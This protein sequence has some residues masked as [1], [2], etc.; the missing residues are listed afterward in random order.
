MLCF[1][2][3]SGVENHSLRLGLMRFCMF[4][5]LSYASATTI[6]KVSPGSL[7]SL[8]PESQNKYM[9]TDLPQSV[10][11]KPAVRGILTHPS[12]LWSNWAM[13]SIRKSTKITTDSLK[14]LR[15]VV[16]CYTLLWKLLTNASLL[17]IK[18]KK[19]AE[20]TRHIIFLTC[21]LTSYLC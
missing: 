10:T 4:C 15:L 3:R 6:R 5:L 14:S 11:H 1:D 20:R 18:N 2:Q 8:Q 7:M 16:I 21:K 12:L 19:Q 17:K 13:K 9:E